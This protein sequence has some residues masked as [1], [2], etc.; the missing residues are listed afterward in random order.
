MKF[1]KKA[2]AVACL[3]SC[4]GLNSHAEK[5]DLDLKINGFASFIGGVNSEDDFVYATYDDDFDF[6]KDTVVGLQFEAR[7]NEKAKLTTQFVAR[8]VEDFDVETE[9]AFLTY[10]VSPDW[11]VRAGRLRTPFFY[12]SDFLEVGYAYQWIRPPVETYAR[13]VVDTYEGIDTIYRMNHGD[14]SSSW[15][16]FYGK[17]ERVIE[18]RI[19]DADIQTETP[20]TTG[21]N[22]VLSNDWLTLRGAFITLEIEQDVLPAFGD[23]LAAISASGFDNVAREWD[24]RRAKRVNYYAFAALVDYND[25]LIN[26][27]F[28][29]SNFDR[30]TLLLNDQSW[31]ILAGRRIGDYTVHLTYS[32]RRDGSEFEGNTIP[33][34]HPLHGALDGVID[35]IRN[36]KDTAVTLGVRY[37]IHA[38]MALKADVTHYERERIEQIPGLSGGEAEGV[39]FSFGVDVVF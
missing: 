9:L 11:D 17:D 32:A 6:E 20:N 13:I 25:W 16:F 29:A 19:F 5:L 14:W 34:A 38:G 37:D 21:V 15:Q 1:I 36:N 39:L 24:T 10:S 3:L 8:G 28:T 33:E 27:E 26:S 23:L 18:S 31:F 2:S 7:V 35:G 12:Y 30:S 4:V 22:V